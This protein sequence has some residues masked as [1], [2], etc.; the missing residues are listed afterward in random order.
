[1]DILKKRKD[2]IEEG[3][4]QAEDARLLLEKTVKRE[5]EMLKQG[6]EEVQGLL[7]EAKK[8]R[9]AFLAEARQDAKNKAQAILDDA[10]RQIAFEINQA[11]EAL[12]EKVVSLA[13]GMLLKSKT[14]LFNK[15]D[16]EFV[17]KHALQ[18]I[19]KG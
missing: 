15:E 2:S 12:S 4:K 7:N 10:R 8:Q 1:M 13:L 3:L 19:K 5:K 14:A 11:E 16:Q 17:M 9:D 6:R 18:E